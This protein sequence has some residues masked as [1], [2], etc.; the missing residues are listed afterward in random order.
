MPTPTTFSGLVEGLINLINLI[1]P[2]IFAVV[3]LVLVWKMFDAWVINSGD[4]K[5]REEGKQF[6]LTAVIVF[7][8]ML[9]VWGIVTMIKLSIFG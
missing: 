6:A 7:V 1:I 8:V 4:E 9:L 2:L 3:F 5:K